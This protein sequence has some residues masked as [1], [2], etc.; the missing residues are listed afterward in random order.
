MLGWPKIC[1]LTDAFLWEYSYKRLTLAQLLGQLGFFLT[2]MTWAPGPS[3]ASAT[4]AGGS[5]SRYVR[6]GAG[7]PPPGEPAGSTRVYS[8]CCIVVYGYNI[9]VWN[10]KLTIDF[11]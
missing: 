9:P 1:K 2:W 6:K 7:S 3:A 4:A 11:P 8:V 10:G 5:W